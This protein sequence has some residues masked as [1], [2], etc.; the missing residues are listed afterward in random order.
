[1]YFALGLVKEI[2]G[3]TITQDNQQTHCTKEH[4]L[5]QLKIALH[6]RSPIVTLPHVQ[7]RVP[8]GYANIHTCTEERMQRREERKQIGTKRKRTDLN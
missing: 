3:H 1:M 2:L 4:L 5:T 7:P 8:H 6:V